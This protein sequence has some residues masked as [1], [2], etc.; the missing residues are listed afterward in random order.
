MRKRAAFFF[1]LFAAT[2]ASAQILDTEVWV[3][4]LDMK[5]GR[6]DVANVTDLSNHPGY[7]NQ[8]AFF[9][10]GATLLYTSEVNGLADNG[11]GLDVQ[12][13][14]LRAMKTTPLAN[15]HG[16]SPTPTADG[17][18]FMLLRDGRVWLHNL[19][20]DVVAPLTETDKAGY[21]ARFDDR[22]WVL[23]MNDEQRR[24]VIYDAKTKKLDTIQPH[25]MTAPFRIP[26]QRAVTFVMQNEDKSRALMRLDVPTRK[27]TTLAKITFPTG[28]HHVWT[29]RGTLLMASGPTIY[30]WNPAKPEEWKAVFRSEHPDLQGISRIAISPKG[31]RIAL[32]STPRDETIIRDSRAASNRGL[33]AHDMDAAFAVYAKD[34][35]VIRTTGVLLDGREAIAAGV[36]PNATYVR[37]PQSIELSTADAAAAEH[38]TWTGKAGDTEMSGSYMTVW[39]KN[40]GENGLPSWTIASEL[41]VRLR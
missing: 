35:R 38:G 10:D 21:Y 3:G 13:V 29:S 11:H 36:A 33:A 8:P 20:G 24:I 27:L 22:T 31:D 40:V 5:D 2:A 39:R 17:K 26:G 37:T 6:F 15:A 12:L 28:G 19:A 16:F 1:L 32:V 30:E 14:D 23:F 4:S 25:A 7:D 34:A 41:F 9:P 18:Q